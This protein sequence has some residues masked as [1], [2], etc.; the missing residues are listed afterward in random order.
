MVEPTHLKNMIV[1]MDHETPIFGVKI[2]NIS[3][4][5]LGLLDVRMVMEPK[6][7]KRFGG[8][9]G[10]PNHHLMFGDWIPRALNNCI[11]FTCLK[12]WNVSPSNIFT[13]SIPTISFQVMDGLHIPRDWMFPLPT[14]SI[15]STS[16]DR[17]TAFKASKSK[18]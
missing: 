2:K 9:E 18:S 3:N 7:Q 1:K 13:F 16:M 10:H 12:H 6:Y 8:D 17:L 5:H 11:F 15:P 14:S 4:H